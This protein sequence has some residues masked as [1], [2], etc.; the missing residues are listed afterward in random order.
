[1]PNILKL[2]KPKGN[3]ELVR[4]YDS[5]A[6]E[7]LKMNGQNLFILA[8]SCKVENPKEKPL[9]EIFSCCRSRILEISKSIKYTISSYSLTCML[10]R[11]EAAQSYLSQTQQPTMRGLRDAMYPHFKPFFQVL[12]ATADPTGVRGWYTDDYYRPLNELISITKDAQLKDAMMQM[13]NIYK[14]TINPDR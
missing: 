6:E 13:I 14:A 1:M 10:L 4:L 7:Y 8:Q 5:L 11:L 3:A 12:E 2:E 9:N